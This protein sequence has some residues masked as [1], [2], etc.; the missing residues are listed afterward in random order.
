MSNTSSIPQSLIDALKANEVVPFVG[1]GVSRAIEKE[2]GCSLFPT[3]KEFLLKA[4]D[5]L[6]RETNP[7]KADVVRSLVNDIPPDYLDAAQ[8]AYDALGQ[9]QWNDLLKENFEI[10]LSSANE[11]TL[12]LAQLVWQLSNNFIVTTNVDL[13]LQSV[14]ESPQRVKVLDTQAPEF[15]ELQR[16]WKP[17]RP[18][19]LHLH[20]HIDNKAGIIFTRAQYNAFYDLD[21]NKAKLETLRTLFTQRTILFIGF[22][23]DDL[24]ILRELERVNLIYEGGANSFYVLIR[25]AEKDNPNIPGYV[26]KITYA[27][28][29]EPLL[30]LVEELSQFSARSKS[31]DQTHNSNQPA[32][33]VEP[34]NKAFFNVPYESKGKEFVGRKG[35]IEEIWSLLSQA[36]CA[37]IGQAVSVKGFGG[38]GKTQLAVEYAHA[39]QDK[40]KNGVF[41]LIADESIDNQLIQIA[42]QRNW[43]NQYDKTVNQLDVAKAKFLELSDCLILFDNVESYNDIKNYL[44]ETDAG[45]HILITSREK[46]SEFHSINLELLDR[47]ES[48]ELLLKVSNR[49]IPNENEKEDLEKILELLGDVPLAIELVGGYLSEHENVTFAKYCQFLNEIP[50]D[51]LEKEFPEG[52]FTHH[53]RSIIRTL[54]I[55]EKLIKEKPLMVEILNILAWSGSS[56]MGTSL[57]KALV[58][59]QDEFEFETALGDAHKLRL[60]KKDDDDE[61]YAVH[62]LLAKV[63]RHENVLANQKDWHRKIVGNLEEWFNERKDEY[64]YL[65]ALD[66][67]TEH[68]KEWQFHTF[69]LLPEISIWLY[70]LEGFLFLPRGDYKKSLELLEKS[71]GLF[72][73]YKLENEKIL[74]DLQ[75]SLGALYVAFG[76]YQEGLQ[77]FLQALEIRK[78][79][80]GENHRDTAETLNNIGNTYEDLGNHQE[81]LTYTLQAFKIRKGLFGEKNN[82]TIGSIYS[83]GT[84][85]GKSGKYKEALQYLLQSLTLSEELFGENHP[86]TANSLTNVGNVYD[87]TGEP[88]KALPYQLRALKVRQELFG[89]KHPIT[90]NSLNNV[91][92]TYSALGDHKEALKYVLLA[93]TNSQETFGNRHPDTILTAANL[94]TA[95]LALG[96]IERAGKLAAEFLNYI[97]FNDPKRLFFE[98]IGAP[99]RKII[100]KKQ[101]RKNKH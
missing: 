45:T 38:L 1:A 56:S 37:S 47:N 80:F 58:E 14:N 77:F 93:F 46:I 89:E 71:F 44:P 12:E 35:K 2:D 16:D 21:K 55:S 53:D 13:V 29:G 31:A 75:D 23:L 63:I 101:R 39:N 48:R 15:A 52:S 82:S 96:H 74:A 33:P 84:I 25:E 28:F 4:A 20:G 79:L 54:R 27:D 34:K 95:Y 65:V 50:L 64:K 41:W 87:R 57:L 61:R 68:L 24:F 66:A 73:S 43:I 76:R 59:P 49:P 81:A 42:D 86:S 6:D 72:Q 10:D 60:L 91:G 40:Y 32:N 90:G 69:E 98:K 62:R 97:P 7:T 17:L 8:R 51:K 78:K 19:V 22:S 36:G 5:K 26:T 99:Y 30:K 85:Y 88:L 92:S 18:T 3:W 67:E 11:K 70:A 83:I 100:H 94:V 9:K